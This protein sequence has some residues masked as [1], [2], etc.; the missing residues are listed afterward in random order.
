MHEATERARVGGVLSPVELRAV[1][2]MLASARALRRFLA[3]RRA[4]AP[5]LFEACSTDP[6]LDVLA[7]EITGS[8]EADG[9]LSA[10]ATT[11]RARRCAA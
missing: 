6:T 10:S 5:A 1:G 2:K 4:Q 3:A 8:F 7:D 11:A 9:T